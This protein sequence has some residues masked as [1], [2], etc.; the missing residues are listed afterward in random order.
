MLLRVIWSFWKLKCLLF[1]F[2][3]VSA[4]SALVKTNQ[5]KS[6]SLT[7]LSWVQLTKIPTFIT[8]V[9]SLG[10]LA[11]PLLGQ[12]VHGELVLTFFNILPVEIV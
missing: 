7:H 12:S 3:F 9:E 5:F 6:I 11:D 2:F 4:V 10:H 1:L 8:E